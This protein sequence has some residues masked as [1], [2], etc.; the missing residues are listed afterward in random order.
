MSITTYV[1]LEN[2]EKLSQNYHQLLLSKCSALLLQ[3]LNY[4]ILISEVDEVE[5][6]KICLEYWNSLAADLYRESPFSGSSSPL[7]LGK[8]HNEMPIRRQLYNPVLSRVSVFWS[9]LTLNSISDK[10]DFLMKKCY[11]SWFSKKTCCSTMK[12]LANCSV[13]VAR[14]WP[15]DWEVL[16]LIPAGHTQDLL[17]LLHV[18][19]AL[20]LGL[21]HVEELG[22]TSKGITWLIVALLCLCV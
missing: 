16:D 19:S 22:H 8:S 15:S 14:A 10:S 17:K 13:W 7:L 5:I 12:S 4:L 6:F 18:L 9:F 1:V 20:L 2:W 11:F 21:Q 3:S